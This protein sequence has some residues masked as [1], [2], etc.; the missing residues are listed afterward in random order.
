VEYDGNPAG[1]DLPSRLGSGKPAAD[2]V[3]RAR[4]IRHAPK[5]CVPGEPDNPSRARCSA[6]RGGLTTH[7]YFFGAKKGHGRHEA[8]HDNVNW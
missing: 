6:R 3:H 1:G 8:G 2:H 4:V 7:R 5:L